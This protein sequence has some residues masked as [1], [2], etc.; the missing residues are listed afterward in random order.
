MRREIRGEFRRV[1]T[2]LMRSCGKPKNFMAYKA[3]SCPILSKADEK[4]KPMIARSRFLEEARDRK[5]RIV[6]E[7]FIIDDES[8]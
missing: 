5:S 3:K 4:S 8:V 1:L 2:L 7:A 6:L